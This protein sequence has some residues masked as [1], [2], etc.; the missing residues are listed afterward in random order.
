MALQGTP[1]CPIP[2]T[3]A[4][5]RTLHRALEGPLSLPSSLSACAVAVWPGS[6]MERGRCYGVRGIDGFPLITPVQT[7]GSV[8]GGSREQN[9]LC[10]CGVGCSRPTAVSAIVICFQTS[11]GSCCRLISQ[12]HERLLTASFPLW[13]RFVA[14]FFLCLLSEAGFLLSVAYPDENEQNSCFNN[15]VLIGSTREFVGLPHP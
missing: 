4:A 12:S 6:E 11:F 9:H 8:F 1:W 15:R 10:V 13:G 2:V 3:R 7:G 14:S 5:A